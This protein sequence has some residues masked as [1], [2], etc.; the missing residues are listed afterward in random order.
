MRDE[1]PLDDDRGRWRFHLVINP[2]H[3]RIRVNNLD[4]LRLADR[5]HG[6]PRG[7]GHE[8][9]AAEAHELFLEGA[10]GLVVEGVVDAA[11]FGD[12]GEGAAADAVE[13]GAVFVLDVVGVA[14]PRH[15]AL[16]HDEDFH[17]GVDMGGLHADKGRVGGVE[18]EVFLRHG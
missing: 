13:G 8:L 14:G 9:L 17:V 11:L 16:L 4:L 2:M 5:G 7:V 1:I 12:E 18:G 6:L 15:D 10:E 3:H